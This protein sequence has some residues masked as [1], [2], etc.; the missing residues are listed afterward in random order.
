MPLT[1]QETKAAVLFQVGKPLRIISL[2]LPRLQAGQV[3]VEVAYSGVCHSQLLEARGK[4]GDDP[5]LPHTLGHEGSGIVLEVGRDVKKA[6]PGDQVILSWMKGSGHDVPSTRYES[7]EGHVHSGAISTF[8][9]KTVIS[10]NRVVP[11][12]KKMPLREAALLGCAIPTGCG[13]VRNTVSVKGG[14]T[15][16]IF[17]VG[18]IGLS[19]VLGA[20][21]A[22]ASEIIAIDISE[23]K[24][25][26]A[27]MLGATVV[28][29]SQKKDAV[30]AILDLTKDR[31]VDYAIECAGNKSAMEQAFKTVRCSGGRCILAGNLAKGDLISIDPF[32]LIKG[33]RI[34]GTWGGE[35]ILDQDVPVYVSQYLSGQLDLG[36]LITGEYPLQNINQALDDLEGRKV[37]G[38]ALIRMK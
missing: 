11:I 27:K 6:K 5:F 22:K 8:M 30:R 38:R 35:T 4:R 1:L 21:Y 7:P 20:R 9:L 26:L 18:G 16:A 13:I 24:L 33:K 37:Q 34:I 14:D 17:G 29:N 32:D 25:K 28:I 2:K 36:R 23:S 12:D 19:V 10:E 3:L 15:I 31:G